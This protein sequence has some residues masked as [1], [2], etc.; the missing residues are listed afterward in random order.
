MA[1]VIDIDQPFRDMIQRVIDEQGLG[2]TSPEL[3]VSRETVRNLL[4]GTQERFNIGALAKLCLNLEIAPDQVG[5][6]P[7]FKP[8]A[9]E[10]ERLSR[11][12]ITQAIRRT[13][14]HR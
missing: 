13:L 5:S 14:E 8:L 4:K 3:G 10:M 7:G 6:M 2:V 9:K 1:R 12:D 11:P